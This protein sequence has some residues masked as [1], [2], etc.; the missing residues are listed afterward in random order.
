MD[1]MIF[2]AGMRLL[3]C[4]LHIACALLVLF[5]SVSVDVC[6]CVQDVIHAI[7]DCAFVTSD[8]PVILS[9]EN[10]CCIS[11]QYRLSKYCDDIFG[12][13]LMKEALPD[14]PVSILAYISLTIFKYLCQLLTEEKIPL[15]SM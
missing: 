11:N 4:V 12:P 3:S 15:S 1:N 2:V 9:F 5:V 14:H 8:W 7:A 10:H 13:L 6:A